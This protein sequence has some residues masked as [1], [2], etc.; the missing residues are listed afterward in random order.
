M[1]ALEALAKTI[2]PSV[3]APTLLLITLTL[4]SSTSI[5]SKEFLTAS[6]EPLTSA[7]IITLISLVPSWILEKS[8]SKLTACFGAFSLA[9][10]FFV[11]QCF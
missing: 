5:R 3:I 8:S 9:L 7:L 4:T 2:S 11:L 10:A 6:A 1:I